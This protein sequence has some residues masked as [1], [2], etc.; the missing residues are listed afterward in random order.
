MKA[1]EDKECVHCGASF[2]LRAVQCG[3]ARVHDYR[4]APSDTQVGGE[5]LVRDGY[6]GPIIDRDMSRKALHKRLEGR[7]GLVFERLPPPTSSE[8]IV[9]PYA[10]GESIIRL[11]DGDELFYAIPLSIKQARWIKLLAG[12]REFMEH[13]MAA[14]II[15]K[16]DWV[17]ETAE[18]D[19]Q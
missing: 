9:L 10:K 6:D 19:G 2:A 11:R 16:C 18:R 12:A 4:P 7:T 3:E 5:W 8:D 17:I 1:P 14:D 15:K 13:P